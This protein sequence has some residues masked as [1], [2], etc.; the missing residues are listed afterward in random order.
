MAMFET[1][2]RSRGINE[3]RVASIPL[4]NDPIFYFQ[5]CTEK[6]YPGINAGFMEICKAVGNTPFTSS[7][8][9]C[10]AG[11]FLAFNTSPIEAAVAISKRNLAVAGQ[12]SKNCVTTCNGCFTSFCNCEAYVNHDPSLLER[13]GVLLGAKNIEMPAD[14]K[15]F[16]VAE[17]FYKNRDVLAKL[18]RH[19]LKSL[20][21]AV[22]YGC[23]FLH[24]E[25]RAVVVDDVEHPRVIE[26]V[27][28]SFK[29]NNV[30]YK[31]K[32]TCCGAGLNQR[33]IK[34]D[35]INSLLLTRRKLASIASHDVDAIVV[36]CPYCQLH[37]DNAQVE[38]EVEFDDEFSI[39]VLHLVEVIGMALGLPKDVLHLDA[40]KVAVEG[41]ATKMGYT[42]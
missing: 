2:S 4:A 38:L 8:Q 21:L 29:G 32:L 11:N 24:Q 25:D 22:H 41:V 40:H 42:G 1:R 17:Y 12:H 9:S 6:V 7:A 18:A 37:L 28:S 10:C 26:D 19:S 3:A 20:R 23:H 34:E 31:E 14:V 5:G 35:R 15:V 16:H 33:I 39:P 36:V 30:D 13:V 27:L